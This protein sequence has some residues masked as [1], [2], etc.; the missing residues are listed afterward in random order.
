MNLNER[1]SHWYYPELKPDKRMN[2]LTACGKHV[3]IKREI[4]LLEPTCETCKSKMDYYNNME[5]E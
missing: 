2:I 3:D 4:D 5:I 1:S